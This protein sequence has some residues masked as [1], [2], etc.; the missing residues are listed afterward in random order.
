MNDLMVEYHDRSMNESVGFNTKRSR[1]QGSIS[2]RF[3]PG[4]TDPPC[5][6]TLALTQS[7]KIIRPLADLM[8]PITDSNISARRVGGSDN[9]PSNRGVEF[10]SKQYS[11]DYPHYNIRS[12]PSFVIFHRNQPPISLITP[13]KWKCWLLEVTSSNSYLNT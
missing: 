8:R 4:S 6:P 2:S 9:A 3:F 7:V 12:D 13:L 1:V 10:L 5:T 11:N